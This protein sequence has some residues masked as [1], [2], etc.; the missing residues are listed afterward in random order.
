MLVLKKYS[1]FFYFFNS[2]KA[3]NFS[4]LLTSFAIPIVAKGIQ[5]P[6]ALMCI[7]WIFAP[8]CSLAIT[9]KP[10]LV[11][12]GIYFFHL[13]GMLYTENMQRGT[14]DMEQKLSLILFPFL[15]ATA[16]PLSAGK[17][18]DAAILFLLGTTTSLIVSYA[19]ASLDYLET[20]DILV[21][22]SSE[23]SIVHHPSYL[24]MY[25]NVAMAIA[26]FMIWDRPSKRSGVILLWFVVIFM[27][28]SLIFTASKAG[29]LNFFL[30]IFFM[31]AWSWH[32]NKI[33]SRNTVYLAFLVIIFLTALFNNPAA[34]DRVLRAVSA[35]TI[36][37]DARS[38]PSMESSRIR[39]VAWEIALSEIVKNPLGVGTGDIND[40]MVKS[41][42]KAGLQSLAD[43]NLNPHNNFL[44]IALAIGIPALFWFLFSLIYPFHKIYKNQN[45][46]YGF[47]LLSIFLNFMVESMLEKQSG[48]IF[49]AFFNALFFF[50][51]PQ[52]RKT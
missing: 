4:V 28:V 38:E 13:V 11:F 22:Y 51:L 48:V 25:M 35:V 44:Q 42:E 29:F 17:I 8:K 31:L 36:T 32:V 20:R 9:W 47:F 39:L 26:L 41:F 24:A 19:T 34:H 21:F 15:F 12:A 14:A 40:T 1:S 3:F 30:L 52:N 10:F 50:S 43:K 16:Q 18:R 49:F 23:F 6:I 7:T 45:R 2:G 27:T 33:R 46:L 5:F 37:P